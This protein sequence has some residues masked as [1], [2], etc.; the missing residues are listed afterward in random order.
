MG[1]LNYA[2]LQAVIHNMS[3]G[4][5]S[6][7]ADRRILWANAAFSQLTGHPLVELLGRRPLDFLIGPGADPGLVATLRARLDNNE[8]FLGELP[9]R[10]RDGSSRW[11]HMAMQPVFDADGVLHEFVAVLTDVTER[12]EADETLRRSTALL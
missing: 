12:R 4:V 8:S 3:A 10:R 2:R 11:V 7:D 1:Q 9:L 6:T 5:C